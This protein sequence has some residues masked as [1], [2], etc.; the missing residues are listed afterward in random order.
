[1]LWIRGVVRTDES[2]IIGYERRMITT[3]KL[4]LGDVPRTVNLVLKRR[5]CYLPY[6]IIRPRSMRQLACVLRIE[7]PLS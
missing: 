4:R 2:E 7:A 3:F 6:G 1:M 5:A